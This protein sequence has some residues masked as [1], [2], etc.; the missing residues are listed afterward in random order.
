MATPCACQILDP[1]PGIK[2]TSPVLGA[3][4]IDR[5]ATRE[6]LSLS[7]K[8]NNV[9]ASIQISVNSPCSFFD[10]MMYTLSRGLILRI[11]LSNIIKFLCSLFGIFFFEGNSV[12]HMLDLL[13]PPSLLNPVPRCGFT[14]FDFFFA[15]VC[16]CVFFA[17][18][19]CFGSSSH[20]TS[21]MALSL[22]LVS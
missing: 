4:G 7:S 1:Q 8:A 14:F 3:Q 13:C 12:L 20:L 11:F 9:H 17:V 2:A 10:Q 19:S 5:W 21:V 6:V 18:S 22:P 16:S 15:T